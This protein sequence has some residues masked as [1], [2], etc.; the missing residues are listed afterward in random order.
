MILVDYRQ[1]SQELIAPLKR[2]G[3]PVDETTLEFGDVAFEG[4]G[5][6]GAPV[7]IGVEVKKLPELVA[8]L[9]SGR[10]QGH[11]LPGM[12]QSYD[13]RWLLIEGDL[14][15]DQKGALLRRAGRRSWAPIPGQMSIGELFKRLHVMHLCAGLVPLWAADQRATI[16]QLEM[17]YRVWTDVD[18][19]EH[20]SH[21]GTYRPPSILPLSPMRTTLQ[22]LP[23]VGP[24]ASLAAQKKFKSIKRAVNANTD[25][26]ASLLLVSPEKT[27]VFGKKHAEFVTVALEEKHG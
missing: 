7:S 22:T 14:Q 15:F 26:W 18:L 8:S 1:G 24:A 9:R 25:E 20:N 2:L 16:V 3:L 27:R 6:K 11:Q 12:C 5:I 21:L 13:Y 10:L 17:L 19:D 4:R 23:Q